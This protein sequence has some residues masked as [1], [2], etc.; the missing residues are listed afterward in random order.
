VFDGWNE[1]KKKGEK[2]YTKVD[3]KPGSVPEGSG[4]GHLSGTRVAPCLKRPYPEASGEQPF[5]RDNTLSLECFPIWS[6]SGWGLS[7]PDV[8]TG[9]GELL[10]HLFTFAP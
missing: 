3:S 1:G 10:P 2:E 5:S 6:C 8:A 9:T 7:A 4:D